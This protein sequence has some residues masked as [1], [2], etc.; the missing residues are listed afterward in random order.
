MKLYNVLKMSETDYDTYDTEYDVCVTVCYIDEGDVEDSYD[1]FCV[2][3]MKKVEVIK[4]VPDSH[5]IVDWSKLIKDNMEN[6]KSFAK[7]HWI[8]DYEND[9]DEFI[10]QWIK[11]INLYLAG[12]VSV[13]FYDNLIKFVDSLKA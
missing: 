5:L 13:D 10:Y 1:K 4:I 11:E 2:Q 6:F 9:E 8:F 3:I 12:Y 7:E